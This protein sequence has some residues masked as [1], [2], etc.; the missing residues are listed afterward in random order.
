MILGLSLA[1]VRICHFWCDV[2]KSLL[3]L[4]LLQMAYVFAIW[5]LQLLPDLG[6]LQADAVKS[7][8]FSL[9]CN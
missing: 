5:V 3:G 8:F 6:R 1:G 2:I 9:L 7:F 4:F